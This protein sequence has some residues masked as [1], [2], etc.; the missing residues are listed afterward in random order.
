[1]FDY[2]EIG[3]RLVEYDME[4]TTRFS[5]GGYCQINFSK[6]FR[7]SLAECS[8]RFSVIAIKIHNSSH[9]LGQILPTRAEEDFN[10]N[11]RCDNL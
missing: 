7:K 2:R 5:K 10:A 6:K 9:F 11:I 4:E 3:I 8:I 1:M